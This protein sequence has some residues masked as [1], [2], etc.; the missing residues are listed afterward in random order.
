MVA[1]N[2]AMLDIHQHST[3]AQAHKESQTTAD[4]P[5]QCFTEYLWR[6][7]WYILLSTDGMTIND[8]ALR[9]Q[10]EDKSQ[11]AV[12]SQTLTSQHSQV[13]YTETCILHS[14]YSHE[15]SQVISHCIQ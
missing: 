11:L 4:F 10:H 13:I 9:S 8:S 15:Y 5:H 14:K 2:R 12:V 1:A 6:E 7:N 3:Y